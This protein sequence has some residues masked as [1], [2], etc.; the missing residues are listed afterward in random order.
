MA[1]R[2]LESEQQ[3][4][5]ILNEVLEGGE[6]RRARLSIEHAMVRRN[7][8]GEHRCDHHLTVARARTFLRRA[9]AQDTALRWIDY[10]IEAFDLNPPLE[11]PN[12]SVLHRRS[13][14]R[15]PECIGRFDLR[16][17]SSSHGPTSPPQL[18]LHRFITRFKAMSAIDELTAARRG[19]GVVCK[20]GKSASITARGQT[21]CYTNVSMK[22]SD[23]FSIPSDS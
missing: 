15:H 11:V 21:L 5:R 1:T 14:S 9:R 4:D 18:S 12:C 13:A 23:I 3:L 20:C 2:A 17:T 22:R 6:E 16:G 8:G 7:R 10:R 19:I